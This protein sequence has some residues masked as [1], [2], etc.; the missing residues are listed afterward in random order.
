MVINRLALLLSQ[1]RP[2]TVYQF[3]N[4]YASLK[5]ISILIPLPPLCGSDE[6]TIS[7][8]VTLLYLYVNSRTMAVALLGRIAVLST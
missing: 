5:G 8:V 6:H 3:V 1:S 4:L 2:I 7:E